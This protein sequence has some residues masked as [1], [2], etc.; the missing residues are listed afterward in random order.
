MATGL[1]LQSIPIVEML[2]L[3]DKAESHDAGLPDNSVNLVST[4]IPSP[5]PGA[6]IIP[7]MS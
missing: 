1:A 6:K 4:N 7:G 3:R 5:E 2:T